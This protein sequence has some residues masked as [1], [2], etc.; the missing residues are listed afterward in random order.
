MFAQMKNRSFTEGDL[1]MEEDDALFHNLY[2]GNRHKDEVLKDIKEFEEEH[3]E[4]VR[5]ERN[6]NLDTLGLLAVEKWNY[7]IK[8]YRLPD[9]DDDDDDSSTARREAEEAEKRLYIDNDETE[10]DRKHKSR[11]SHFYLAQSYQIGYAV[12][13]IN[14]TKA[15]HH[16]QMSAMMDLPEAMTCLGTCFLHG[17]GTD[18]DVAEAVRWYSKAAEAGCSEGMYNLALCL[19][20]GV[21]VQESIGMAIQWMNQSAADEHVDAMYVMAMYHMQGAG[22]IE[23]NE[24]LANE[25]LTKIVDR[26]DHPASQLSLAKSF[27]LGRGTERD[28][29]MAVK[30]AKFAAGEE[31]AEKL[32]SSWEKERRVLAEGL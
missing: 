15:F 11:V 3:P 17:Y 25:M 14:H 22:A 10:E 21:G 2:Y 28:E 31:E 4:V 26:F 7:H 18:K 12:D 16:F 30:L 6:V 19:Q 27:L 24:E 5:E 9:Y 1:L 8:R 13:E 32:I 29:T 23:K 20:D